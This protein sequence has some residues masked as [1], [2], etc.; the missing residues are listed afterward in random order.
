MATLEFDSI[1]SAITGEHIGGY[2]PHVEADTGIDVDGCDILI[3]G[4][5]DNLSEWG[6][7]TGKTGQHGYRGAIMHA[8]ETADDDTIRAWARDAGGD[9][10]AIV[11]VSGH[12]DAEPV[13]PDEPDYCDDYGCAHQP[14][15]WAII[16]RDADA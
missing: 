4:M 8:S 11:V 9:L 7:V 5:P 10:F 14:A 6:Q 12:D 3:D 2:V 13:F 1:Y 15:G 16:Y